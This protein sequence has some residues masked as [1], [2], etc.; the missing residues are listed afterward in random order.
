MTV[1]RSAIA[2][3]GV[4]LLCAGVT[5]SAR[6]GG[7]GPEP[8]VALAGDNVVD[9][10][11]APGDLAPSVT[12]VPAP[13]SLPPIAE[14]ARRVYAPPP[15]ISRYPRAVIER[16][17]VVPLG[18]MIASTGLTG[19]P[20]AGTFG[21]FAAGVPFGV[22]VS[23][24]YRR[25]LTDARAGDVLAG[26]GG[27][28]YERGALSIDARTELAHDL[29][30][31]RWYDARIGLEA[32]VRIGTKVSVSLRPEQ[33]L[34]APE[35]DGVSRVNVPLSVG[36]QPFSGLWLRVDGTMPLAEL[37]AGGL[38]PIHSTSPSAAAEVVVSPS[39]VFDLRARVVA[40]ERGVGWLLGGAYAFGQR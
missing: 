40:D 4:S 39:P 25:R 13:A 18:M 20:Q 37:D 22:D 17:S 11:Y 34:L 27:R 32:E 23:L 12:D 14:A 15:A 16:P 24:G 31:Q 33:L 19:G 8:D 38:R 36:V 21:R 7:Y 5:T 6:A 30:D 3:L 26:I 35:D 28:L 2:T 9:E 1:K 10:E 29:E